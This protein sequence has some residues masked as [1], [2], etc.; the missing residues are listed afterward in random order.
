MSRAACWRRVKALEEDGVI[1]RYGSEDFLVNIAWGKDRTYIG[2]R[3]YRLRLASNVGWAFRVG[4]TSGPAFTGTVCGVSA[5]GLAG[6]WLH[7][8]AAP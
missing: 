7:A 6:A 8:V 3:G 5:G 1:Q 2:G 4:G